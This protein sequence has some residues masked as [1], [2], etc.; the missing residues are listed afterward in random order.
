M[1][2]RRPVGG[3]VGN[4]QGSPSSHPDARLERQHFP[5]AAVHRVH[6]H[7]VFMLLSLPSSQ[8]GGADHRR[9]GCAALQRYFSGVRSNAQ[10]G[11]WGRSRSCR[12]ARKLAWHLAHDSRYKMNV[13]FRKAIVALDF[14]AARSV[15]EGHL[16][17]HVRRLAHARETSRVPKSPLPSP[18]YSSRRWETPCCQS[19]ADG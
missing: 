16:A 3:Q 19:F 12:L 15:I 2:S 9:P 14:T 8:T 4:P 5:K 18:L 10:N 1:G 7:D 13:E 6:V 17:A 11:Q